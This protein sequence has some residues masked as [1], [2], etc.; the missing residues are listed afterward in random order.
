MAQSRK[1]TE[2]E[3]YSNPDNS[4]NF[5][6][7]TVDQNYRITFGD[8]TSAI[9]RGLNINASLDDLYDQ[10]GELESDLGNI[11]SNFTNQLNNFSGYF[12]NEVDNIDLSEVTNQL[13]DVSGYFQQSID[14]IDLPKDD[15]N[16]SFVYFNS[17]VN[18]DGAEISTYYDTP[19]QNIFLSGSSVE[20]SS[21]LR[22]SLRWDGPANDYMGTAYIN[23][24]EI[25]KSNIHELGSNTRRFEGYIDNFDA[26][27]LTQLTGVVN[28]VSG[29]VDLITIGSGPS[30]SNISIDSISNATPKNGEELGVSALKAG[31]TINIFVDYDASLFDVDL[32]TPNQIEISD[33]GIADAVSFSN[34]NFIDIGN[35]IKRATIPVTVSNRIGEQGVRVRAVNNMGSTGIYQ[36]S[37]IDFIGSDDS[38]LLDQDYPIISASSPSSYN[39]RSDGLRETESTSFNNSISNFDISS[40]NILYTPSVVNNSSISINSPSVFESTKTVSYLGGVYA[41]QDNLNIKVVRTANGST[42]SEDLTIKVANGPVIHSSL[43]ITPAVSSLSQYIIGQSELKNGDI[44]NVKAVIDT[45]GE[46]SGTIKLKVFDSGISNGSQTGFAN[47][48]ST[49]LAST[50]RSYDY[51][52][53][54]GDGINY[55]FNGDSYG[56]DPTLYVIVGDTLSFTNNTGG[57][58]LAIKNSSDV[59]QVTESGGSLSFNPT[60]AGTYTYYCTVA[61]HQN[62]SGSI[63]VVDRTNDLYEYTIP[64]V[65]TSSRNG[66]LNVTLQAQNQYSTNSDAKESENSTAVNNSGPSVNITSISYPVNQ[67]AIKSGEAATVNNSASNYDSIE[68]IDP[69]SGS[70]QITISN[71]SVF[72]AQKICTYNSGDYNISNNNFQITATKNSNGLRASASTV[73]NISNS[74]LSLSILNLE[75]SLISS[76]TG[77]SDSFNLVSDQIYKSA[78]SLSTDSNQNPPSQLS[79]VSSGTGLTSN[80]FTITVRDIDEKGQF[81]WI[82]S[83]FN[84]ANIETTSITTNPNYLISGFSEREITASPNSLAAGL[85]AIG[86]TV[87]NPSNVS[88]ENISE[89]GSGPNGGTIYSFLQL[90]EGTQLDFTFNHD[91]KFCV[92]NSSGVVDNNGDH[93]FNLDALSRAANAD[94]NNPA[95]YIVKED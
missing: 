51:D 37:D 95:K 41:N 59:I 64:V 89:G 42:D 17:I 83:A 12:Q 68:Y 53:V 86:T 23:Q 56:Q 87:T 35:S 62:M 13:N 72:E 75:S 15:L 67:E 54:S 46:S 26:G 69:T 57:H 49:S 70:N 31:D 65:V 30:A 92:C 90:S 58:P 6:V 88:F 52:L 29:F 7:A 36:S 78:P 60:V 81:S 24:I 43:I 93:L 8:L 14:N 71:S 32:T 77:V 33:Y 91:N 85:A 73:V 4:F 45:Q 50:T 20:S 74:P 21:N 38:R 48:S 22:V 25:P 66:T 47:F 27:N 84:L 94:V 40:D 44:V 34:Y 10:I 79:H 19:T 82:V 2:L 80:N 55:T 11:S 18:N 76:N 5:L 3:S 61:G 1:I 9:N 16:G 39:G 28:G 63:I